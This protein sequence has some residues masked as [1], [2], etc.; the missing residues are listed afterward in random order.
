MKSFS[1]FVSWALLLII[2]G[3][4]KLSAQHSPEDLLLQH[5]RPKSIYKVPYTD[6]KKPC[7]PVIDMHSHAYATTPDEVKL[8]VNIMDSL[9][10]EKVVILSMATGVRFDSIMELYG[11]YPDRFIVYCGL[12]YSK[13][14]TA[15]F[16]SSAI[17]ELERCYRK[18]AR[19]VGELGDKGLG[20]LYSWPRPAYGLHIDD[21]LLKPIYEKCADLNMPVNIHVA[22]PYWFY[23]PMDSTNDGLMNAWKWRIDVSNPDNRD[24]DALIN[25]LENV[26]RDNPRTTFIA[27]HYANLNHDL[28]RLGRM[29]DKYPNLYADI[30]ARYAEQSNIPRYMR[31][32][33]MKYQHKLLYGTDMGFDISMYRLTFRILETADEHFY[34]TDLFNY[35]WALNGWEI[36]KNILRKVYYENAVNIIN[37]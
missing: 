34:F 36:P 17:K 28:E 16:P 15:E 20:E 7:C 24:Y 14:G 31:N 12:D 27:A 9:G 3:A 21:P 5:Y 2:M 18:G 37:K 11:A 29:L 33:F 13:Y 4:G 25:S 6:V 1:T 35:H 8:W 22:E 10:I 19:G 26:V 32:F 30:S 23:L